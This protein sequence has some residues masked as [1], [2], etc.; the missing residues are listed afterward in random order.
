MRWTDECQ[1]FLELL[2]LAWPRFKKANLSGSDINGSMIRF[3]S[4]V[5]PSRSF[6]WWK[7]V[8][9]LDSR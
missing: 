7:I 6:G 8:S 3:R 1:L 9:M 2:R 5:L 4:G